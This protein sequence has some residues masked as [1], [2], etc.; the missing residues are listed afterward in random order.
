M[1][2]SSD[3]ELLEDETWEANLYTNDHRYRSTVRYD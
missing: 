3:D 1:I 2:R